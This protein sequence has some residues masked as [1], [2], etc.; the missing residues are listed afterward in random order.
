MLGI[1]V[2]LLAAL[3]NAV[4]AI[5]IK[6]KIAESTVV[7]AS[8]I[9]TAIGGIILWPFALAVT[10]LSQVNFQ[11]IFFFAIAGMLAPGLG[12]L[13]YFKGI[14][15]VGASVTLSIWATFPLY[16]TIAAVLM[17]NETLSFLNWIGVISI[18]LGALF[19][20]RSSRTPGKD[21]KRFPKKIL[22]IPII[23]TL[24]MASSSIIRKYGLNLYSEPILGTA[25]GYASS[26][27]VCLLFIGFT[28]SNRTGL[29]LKREIMLFWKAGVAV[30][31]SSFL[32][33]LAISLERVAIVTPLLQVC[34]LF[35]ILFA[36]LFLKDVE[37][38]SVKL[39]LS[40]FIVIIGVLLIVSN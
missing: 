27:L 26:L 29:N 36:Y 35:T 2:A 15:T 28:K 31:I 33:Y 14:E 24:F 16:T 7:H 12:R 13:F 5:L 9:I 23:G 1:A 21:G 30:A 37:R 39:V 19:I 18:V 25:I 8:L 6:Q 32:I 20:E 10:D 17:L 38:I 11:A 4:A 34:A 3:A 22:I 40:T